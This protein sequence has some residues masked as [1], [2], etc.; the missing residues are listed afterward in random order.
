MY[1]LRHEGIT[2]PVLPL[3]PKT[4]CTFLVMPY[5]FIS[6]TIRNLFV[7]IRCAFSIVCVHSFLKYK[8]FCDMYFF[9]YG[10]FSYYSPWNLFILCQELGT[11]FTLK[12]VQCFAHH[13][14]CTS[15]G[16]RCALC[17]SVI[18]GSLSHH[19]VCGSLIAR[20]SMYCTSIIMI[21]VHILRIQTWFPTSSLW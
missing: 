8:F 21:C 3:P 20:Y 9:Y 11:L 2:L 5:I 1:L 16:I 6:F 17:I 18:M 4:Q 10:V 14:T 13:E 12:F 15:F 19:K 7:F